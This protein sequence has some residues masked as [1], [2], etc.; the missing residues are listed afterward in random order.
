MTDETQTLKP[1]EP[2][3][4]ALTRPA[5]LQLRGEISSDVREFMHRPPHW[6]LRSGTTVLTAVM[7]LLLV[8]SLVIKYPDTITGRITVIGTQPVMEVVAR[9]SG[10]LESL[11]VRE[12]QHVKQGE[13]LAVMQSPARPATV[14][15]LTEKLR[16]VEPGS[17]E[18]SP[19]LKVSFAPKDDL[20][21][22][23]EPY[24][25]FLNSYQQLQSRL[26][27]DYAEK[28]GALLRKQLE[29]KRAQIES[30]RSQAGM[31]GREMGLARE[32]L[33]RL[34]TLHQSKAISTAE[35]Q[36]QEMA[37][38]E[39]M[40][41]E[42]TG[43][44][45]LNEAEIEASKSEKELRDLEHDRAESLRTAREELRARLNKLLGEIGLWEADYLLRAPGEG[46][47]AFYD[48]WSDQ[49]FVTAGRQ[50]FLIVPQT[51]KLLGRMPVSQGGSGKIKPGQSV[52]IQLDDFPYK[53]FGV[54]SGKVQSVSMVA[55]EGAN[56]VLVDI[57][58][59]LVTSF[60]KKLLFKQEMVGEARIV[61]E[62]IRLLGRILYEIRR[63]FIN[64]TST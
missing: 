43:Q 5:E 35:M 63:A 50:V 57:P 38:L 37:V 15:E 34:K 44:R 36:E 61:T 4:L 1:P 9:Q 14:L 25:D 22:L 59:P 48:F 41:E 39:R 52:R 56:L 12:G 27:D 47:V 31:M 49:Q 8:L 62:D 40:R 21:K 42:T 60:H 2:V 33:D 24:A 32:K 30:L 58:H 13:I 28:A 7:A 55:R 10:H 20:G 46:N 64:S 3:A 45:T 29:G 26:A 53:E 23:Q 51:T 16:Q 6:L 17:G 11:R 19:V 54:V 18:K